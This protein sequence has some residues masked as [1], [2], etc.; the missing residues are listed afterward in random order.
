MWLSKKEFILYMNLIQAKE[1]WLSLFFC[2]LK[3][4]SNRIIE[5]NWNILF[6]WSSSKDWC[7][8]LYVNTSRW[9]WGTGIYFGCSMYKCKQST[10]SW[11]EKSKADLHTELP[12]SA[13]TLLL[14]VELWSA[15]PPF[16][17]LSLFPLAL[18]SPWLRQAGKQDRWYPSKQNDPGVPAPCFDPAVLIVQA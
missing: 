1:H 3:L 17:S 9:Y 4:F 15:L 8:L 13:S 14:P 2:T 16:L 18:P 10:A 12:S 5:K 6:L 7:F 11:T